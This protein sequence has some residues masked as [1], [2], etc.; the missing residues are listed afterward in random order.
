M[1]GINHYLYPEIASSEVMHIL[2]D[3]INHILWVRSKLEPMPEWDLPAED[4]PMPFTMTALMEKLH[5]NQQAKLARAKQEMVNPCP[6]TSMTKLVP[7]MQI[8]NV[9]VRQ[10]KNGERPQCFAHTQ[11]VFE[12]VRAVWSPGPRTPALSSQA[13]IE[14]EEAAEGEVEVVG[15]K[16]ARRRSKRHR[17][18]RLREDVEKVGKGVVE[19]CDVDG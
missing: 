11:A 10:F 12:T 17:R 7:D 14:H 19:L 13:V 16:R 5:R 15:Q 1:T 4:R 3:Q 2:G 8:G 6:I 9:R 18:R